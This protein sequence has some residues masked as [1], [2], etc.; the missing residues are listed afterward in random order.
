MSPRSLLRLEGAVILAAAVFGYA[1]LGASWWLFFTLLLVPDVFMVGYL[2]GPRPGAL[3]YNVGH[4]YALPISIGA[5]GV[6]VESVLVGAVAL[7]WIAHIGMD[8]AL[9]YGLKRPSGFHDTH[10]S[11][12]ESD[13]ATRDRRRDAAMQ[14]ALTK[15]MVLGLV[16]GLAACQSA[17][18]LDAGRWT[19]TLTPMNH[20]DM[21]TPV[22]YDVQ[23]E[24]TRLVIDLIGPNGTTTPTRR[25]R[26]DGDTLFFSFEEPEEQV[27]LDC[28]LGRADTEA[29][30]GR[31]ADAAGKWARFTMIPSTPS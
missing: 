7:I 17:P 5:I 14:S 13:P 25:P 6:G 22:A 16:F 12:S 23:Y 2:A 24:G 27:R 20:P 28:A 11:R 10:L 30:A 3:V 18:I 15:T 19:G 4:T 21:A 9:G 31:C 1:V 29:F 8:R 26:L